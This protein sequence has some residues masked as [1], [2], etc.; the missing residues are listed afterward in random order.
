MTTRIFTLLTLLAALLPVATL[1]QETASLTG[2][3][4]DPSGAAVANAQVSVV[5]AD[6]GINRTTTTNESGEYLVAGLPSGAFDVTVN[7][8]GFRRYEA[9]GVILQVAQKA[10]N[11]VR[12]VVGAASAE[13]TVQGTNVA[14][15]ETQSS[16]LSGAVT[17]KQITQLELNGRNFTQQQS[18]RS[19]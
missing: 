12:L 17:G 13:V 14:Q 10:R 15:V 19:R 8:A 11:D 7:A 4:T 3:V 2:T 16:D 5:S 9:K 18:D 1:A 6:R